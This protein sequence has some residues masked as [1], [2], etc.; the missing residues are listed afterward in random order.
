MHLPP[1]SLPLAADGEHYKSN[2]AGEVVRQKWAAWNNPADRKP[3]SKRADG[4]TQPAIPAAI[5]TSGSGWGF[6]PRSI[7]FDWLLASMNTT[8]GNLQSKHCTALIRTASE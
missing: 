6:F 5:S 7:L 3:V 2:W 8:G 1:F 4:G